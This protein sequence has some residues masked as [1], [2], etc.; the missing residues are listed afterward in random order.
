MQAAE[1][2]VPTLHLGLGALLLRHGSRRTPTFFGLCIGENARD[3]RS[4]RQRGCREMFG[5]VLRI[6]VVGAVV[7][8]RFLHILNMVD[9]SS[10][11]CR[12]K[13]SMLTW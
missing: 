13:E 2:E 1:L 12:R 6:A 7:G 11:P 8:K 10:R 4:S 3:V 5:L 9:W